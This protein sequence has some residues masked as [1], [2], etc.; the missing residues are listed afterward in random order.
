M[1]NRASKRKKAGGKSAETNAN[2][3]IVGFTKELFQAAIVLRGS[4]EPADY[5]R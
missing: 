1:A 3:G 4:I 5:K 2:G